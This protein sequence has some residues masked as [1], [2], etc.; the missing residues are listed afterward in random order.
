LAPLITKKVQEHHSLLVCT[1][2]IDQLADLSTELD[3]KA[4]PRF[5]IFRAGQLVE[6]FI[7]SS[8]AD[9]DA[10]FMRAISYVNES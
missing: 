10:L 5:Q 3:I 7:G 8:E 2:D 1:V 4:V 9:I 6:D